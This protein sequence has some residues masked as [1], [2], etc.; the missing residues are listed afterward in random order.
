MQQLEYKISY[1][2]YA[3]DSALEAGDKALLQKAKEA[4][5]TAYAPYSQFNVGAA[6]LLKNGQIVLGSNQEN[7]ASPSGLCAERVAV[8][9][10]GTQYPNEAIE[11]IAITCTTERFEVDSPISPCGACRQAIL[12]YEIRHQNKIKVILMGHTGIVRIV[13]SISD[14]LP[15][16]FSSKSI[17][18]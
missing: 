4:L 13:N 3:N 6:V 18:K 5:K 7:A 17:L 11:A 2:E 9:A 12:E 15:F 14:L 16:A 8:Y 10:A 1:K